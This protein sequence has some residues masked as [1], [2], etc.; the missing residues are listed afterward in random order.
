MS[1]RILLVYIPNEENILADA[2]SRFQEILDWRLHP[3]VFQ[4]IAARWG[5]PVIDL[6]TSNASKLTKRFYSLNAFDN[7][8][9]VD[10]LS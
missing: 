9:G 4:A 8:E 5:L 6:F 10:A 7:P 1:V 2:A 3:N